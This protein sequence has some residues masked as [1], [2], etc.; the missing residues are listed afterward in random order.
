MELQTKE[1]LDLQELDLLWIKQRHQ[2]HKKH[3]VL[4]DKHHYK[5]H[6]IVIAGL[7]AAT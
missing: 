2:K 1:Q 5:V 3:Q 6:I 4:F 7:S